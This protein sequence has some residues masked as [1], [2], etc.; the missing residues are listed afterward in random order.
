MKRVLLFIY[1]ILFPTALKTAAAGGH[2]SQLSTSYANP[3]S[4]SLPPRHLHL[5]PNSGRGNGPTAM[6]P[7]PSTS[8]SGASRDT[9]RSFSTTDHLDRRATPLS[10]NLPSS[11]T[12]IAPPPFTV[13]QTPHGP[14]ACFIYPPNGPVIFP[15]PMPDAPY[16]SPIIIDGSATTSEINGA[17]PP[18]PGPD[19]SRA[20]PAQTA[21]VAAPATDSITQDPS[22]LLSRAGSRRT[23]VNGSVAPVEPRHIPIPKPLTPEEIVQ[24]NVIAILPRKKNP[25]IRTIE[26]GPGTSSRAA[27]P[28]SSGIAAAHVPHHINPYPSISHTGASQTAA[29]GMTEVAMTEPIPDSTAGTATAQATEQP[30]APAKPQPPSTV[31]NEAPTSPARHTASRASAVA[32]PATGLKAW[33]LM[34]CCCTCCPANCKSCCRT[35]KVQALPPSPNISMNAKPAAKNSNRLDS[36][37]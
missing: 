34:H 15:A 23:S 7:S 37:S 4:S 26:V 21:S 33:C 18:P 14:V 5:P 25:T 30:S 9:G 2:P 32:R 36:I 22:T 10:Q 16:I 20:L 28:L 11:T 3:T 1:L 8:S 27:P 35:Y 6:P 31:R 19:T 13:V 29:V 17:N 12:F 24:A